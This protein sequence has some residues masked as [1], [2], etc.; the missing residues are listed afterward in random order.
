MGYTNIVWNG[1]LW[2]G[3]HCIS[4]PTAVNWWKQA[5]NINPNH[6]LFQHNCSRIE[7]ESKAWKWCVG[8][9]P[10]DMCQAFFGFTTLRQCVSLRPFCMTFPV[11]GRCYLILPF[12]FTFLQFHQNRLSWLSWKARILCLAKKNKLAACSCKKCQVFKVTKLQW[13]YVPAPTQFKQNNIY[14]NEFIKTEYW[15]NQMLKWTSFVTLIKKI[16]NPPSWNTSESI[17]VNTYSS[18]NIKLYITVINNSHCGN[19]LIF[20]LLSFG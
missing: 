20:L 3:K 16:V 17:E 13:F 15:C 2:L 14:S 10:A 9:I 11:L 1:R 18:K 8:L 5:L 19:D 12:P 4:V 7:G 6:E